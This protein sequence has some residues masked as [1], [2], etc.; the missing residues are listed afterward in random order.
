[1]LK[2]K[3][4][5]SSYRYLRFYLADGWTKEELDS[6]CTTGEVAC[7]HP[8]DPDPYYI[9]D[10][11]QGSKFDCVKLRAAAS[12]LVRNWDEGLKLSDVQYMEKLQ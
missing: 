8:D 10:H 4:I 12:E 6:Y 1:M 9:L 5:H 11:H 7:F 3:T 2:T